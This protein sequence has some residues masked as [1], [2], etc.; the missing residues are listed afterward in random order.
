M[1]PFDGEN[2]RR[3]TQLMTYLCDLSDIGDTGKE[4]MVPGEPPQHL[5]LFFIDGSVRAFHNVCPHAG[6]SLSFGPDRFLFTPEGLLVCPHHGASFDLD[7]DGVCIAGPCPGAL[8]KSVEIA[9]HEGR[10]ELA[11]AAASDAGGS[12]QA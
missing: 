2:K 12:C 5:M 1:P 9:V 4:L 3:T 11:E 7:R 6:R 10:V 8:L